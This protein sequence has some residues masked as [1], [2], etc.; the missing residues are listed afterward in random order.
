MPVVHFHYIS[1]LTK[2]QKKDLTSAITKAVNETIGIPS[3]YVQ[4]WLHQTSAQDHSIGGVLL[5]DLQK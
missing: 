1:A 3:E 4:I 5:E 2:E